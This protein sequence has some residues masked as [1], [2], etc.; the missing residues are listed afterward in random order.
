MAY[1]FRSSAFKYHIPIYLYIIGIFALSSIPPSSIPDVKTQLPMDKIVHFLEYGIFGIL[2]FRVIHLK[3]KVIESATISIFIVAALGA[4]DESY[5]T[6]T[7]RTTDVKDWITDCL[8]AALFIIG[9]I[10]CLKIWEKLKINRAI[11]DAR[12]FLD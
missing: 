2:V 7:H 3:K 9:F 5:Q 1:I 4:I 6:L 12:N 8:G 10:I 11:R